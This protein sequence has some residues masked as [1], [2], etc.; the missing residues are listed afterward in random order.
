LAVRTV[1]GGLVCPSRAVF[2]QALA[3]LDQRGL[4]EGLLDQREQLVLLVADVIG[5]AAAEVV[6]QLRVGAVGS[7]ST[8][9]RIRTWSTSVRTTAGWSGSP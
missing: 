9:L 3:E 2:A 8:S 4:G 7:R 6:E 1:V 5:E